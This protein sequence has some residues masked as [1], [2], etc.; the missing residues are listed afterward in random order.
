MNRRAF[1]E[2]IA[3]VGGLAVVQPWRLLHMLGASTPSEAVSRLVDWGV[4]AEAGVVPL[5]YVSRVPTILTGADLR[6][7]AAELP[8]SFVVGGDGASAI[9]DNTDLSLVKNGG[10][11]NARVNLTGGTVT[12]IHE[13]RCTVNANMTNIP[14]VGLR[15][16]TLGL[17][18]C[19]WRWTTDINVVNRYQFPLSSTP[20]V[21]IFQ[22]WRYLQWHRDGWDAINGT[23]SWLSPMVRL[24]WQPSAGAGSSASLILDQVHVG[25]YQAPV[26]PWVLEGGSDTHYSVAFGAW[27]ALRVTG[28]LAIPTSV[29]GTGGFLSVSQ[30]DEMYAAGWDVIHMSDSTT[31]LTGL[32][33]QQVEDRLGAAEAYLRSRG[34]VRTLRHCALP[35]STVT[36]H[37][38]DA[39]VLTALANRGYL[40]A[41]DK[42]QDGTSGSSAN[43]IT[44]DPEYG[45][46]LN[47]YRVPAWRTENPDTLSEHQGHVRHAIRSGSTRILRTGGIAGVPSAGQMATAD[48]AALLSEV[49]LYHHAGTLRLVPFR[50]FY[51]GL[52]GRMV[53]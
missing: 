42:W 2:R 19:V 34:W 1:L 26:I 29:I 27:T 3:L 47:P 50:K 31:A 6:N 35:G 13:G 12:Q 24:A 18:N 20:G 43:G 32:S 46:S 9:V 36:A 52:S 44:I 23:P 51:S 53:R 22:G 14:T 5:N 49:A 4:S 40:S 39:N 8:T 28:T 37:R 15:L 11:R 21:S 38:S 48:H 16:Y 10:V 25:G 41:I 17:N 33:V 7:G 45:I 30:I